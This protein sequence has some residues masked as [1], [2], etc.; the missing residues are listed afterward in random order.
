MLHDGFYHN[1]EWGQVKSIKC[2]NTIVLAR[3]V[4]LRIQLAISVILGIGL[5]L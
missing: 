2:H 5:I 1:G 4:G 3:I